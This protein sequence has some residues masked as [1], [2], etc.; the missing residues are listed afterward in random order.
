MTKAESFRYHAERS[1][2]KRAATPK[3][4]PGGSAAVPPHRHNESERASRKA[5]YALE[6][7][8]TRPSRKSTRKASNR[9]KN[10]VQFRMKRQTSELQPGSKPRASAR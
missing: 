5:L 4:V 2:L 3:S 9:Q 8:A 7:S 1:G 10:D 6:D